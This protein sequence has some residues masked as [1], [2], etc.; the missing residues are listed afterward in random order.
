MP[1]RSVH[2]DP[3]V[4]RANLTPKRHLDSLRS[5]ETLLRRDDV[6]VSSSQDFILV[7]GA[8]PFSRHQGGFFL[9]VDPSCQ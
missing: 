5:P 4:T 9:K 7:A 1:A 8:W 3:R 2:L 6:T